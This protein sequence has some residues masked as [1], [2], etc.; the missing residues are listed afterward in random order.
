MKKLFIVALVLISVVNGLFAQQA[1]Q[2][3]A[4]GRLGL[5]AGFND[6]LDFYDLGQTFYPDLVSTSTKPCLQ[7]NVALY[8]NYS[9][10]NRLSLQAELNFLIYQGYDLIMRFP[11]G[12]SRNAEISYSSLDIPLLLKFDILNTSSSFG[13]LFG[14]HI[15]IPLGRVEFYREYDFEKEDKIH[16]ESFATYGLTAGLFTGYPLGPGRLVGDIRF[17]F[18]F[19]S[20][21]VMNNNI[22]YEI[23]KR[24]ALTFSVGYEFS[25]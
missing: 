23:M 25:F 4:G 24:Q 11:D 12:I 1:G 17:I 3:S 16:I 5:G 18:D 2:F 10:T 19:N 8:G 20:L 7:F 13:I 9:F 6:S 15:S 14:P 21:E 22:V